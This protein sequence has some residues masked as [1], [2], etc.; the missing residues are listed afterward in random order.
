[1]SGGSE[2]WN[3]LRDAA[4]EDPTLIIIVSD[5][6]PSEEALEVDRNAVASGPPV[7]ALGIGTVMQE[8]LD[9]IAALSGGSTAPAIDQ[10][11]AIEA[12][13]AAIED[14]LLDDYIFTYAASD[15]GAD[16]RA[17]EV[18]VNDVTAETT[19]DVPETPVRPPAIAGLYLTIR[20][21]SGE[22]T[23]ALAGFSKGYITSFQ[24]V[25]QAMLD[26][27]KALFYGRVSISFEAA[28]PHHPSCWMTGSRRSKRLSRS[29]TRSRIKTKRPYWRRSRTAS[30]SH[31]RSFRSRIRRCPA[32][33]KT[34]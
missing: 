17:V 27:V 26:D 31:R 19:Y 2:I 3:A 29:T 14:S 32:E 8:T 6:M 15:E 21:R 16:E 34:R 11:A 1:M 4:A 12:S 5:G 33:P 30:R 7:L 25:T 24:P 13:I 18:T 10:M 28:S 22:V 23:R 20:T 9:D